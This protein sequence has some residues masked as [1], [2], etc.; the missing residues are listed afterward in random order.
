MGIETGRRLPKAFFILGVAM[1]LVGLAAV[2]A[3][4]LVPAVWPG[5][6][7]PTA[8]YVVGMGTPFGLLIAIAAT[9][10]QGRD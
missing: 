1:F 7:A 3:L 2:G 8:V 10:W 4:F 5:H 6:V 9:V